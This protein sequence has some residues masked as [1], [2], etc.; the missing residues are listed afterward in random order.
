MMLV[1]ASVVAVSL[2]AA[3]LTTVTPLPAD[4]APTSSPPRAA[5]EADAPALNLHNHRSGGSLIHF[6]LDASG[7]HTIEPDAAD[8][9]NRPNRSGPLLLFLPATRAEPRQYR[10]FLRTAS[11][12]GY[13]VLGLDYWNTGRSVTRTCGPVAACY[14]AIQQNRFDGS[15]PSAYS[16]VDRRNSVLSRVRGA[17]SYL[18]S[19]DK[20]GGWGRYTNGSRVRWN[21]IVLAGHS[22]GGG[23]SAYIAHREHV[24]GVLM[25]SSPVDTDSGVAASWMA[26]PGTTNPSRM[27]AFDNVN[28]MYFQKIVGS[29][30]ALGLARFGKTVRGADPTGSHRLV[31]TRPIGD[32][33]QSH[34]RTVNDSTPVSARGVPDYQVVWRW[35]LEQVYHPQDTSADA[36]TAARI[37]S[38]A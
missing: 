9:A 19:H 33:D 28:D 16:A 25:F 18:R 12:V 38:G 4:A 6:H 23:E 26:R 27:Y 36:Q 15:R 14:T 11:S 1:T 10:G 7:R 17:L 34:G 30:R 13:H 24:Q 35:M 22:Q 8:Y 21:R 29:W 31:S 32:G 3:I 20:D 2:G 5:V 37:H